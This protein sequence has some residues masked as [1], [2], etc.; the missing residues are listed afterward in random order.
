M[1][2]ARGFPGKYL[3]QLEFLKANGSADQGVLDSIESY[4]ALLAGAVGR[5]WNVDEEAL[6]KRPYKLALMYVDAPGG[7]APGASGHAGGQDLVLRYIEDIL[8]SSSRASMLALPA[9]AASFAEAFKAAREA[10]ADYF[11]LI[12]FRETERDV[13]LDVDLRV[14]RTGS[15]ATSFRAYRTGNDR[16]KNS[17]A[18]TA[19]L[20]VAALPPLGSLVKRN[21]ESVLV[22]LGKA[23]GLAAG[24]KLVVVKEGSVQVKPE[25]LGIGY[26][27]SAVLAEVTVTAVGEE[28]SSGTIKSAGFFDTVNIGDE[29]LLAPPTA[30]PASAATAEASAQEAWPGLFAAVK[31]LR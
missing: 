13:E 19:E 27:Q 12:S 9:K 28:A 18:R 17:A 23:D 16:L 25:G 24:A 2:K 3:A 8:A 20:L 6:A 30:A 4:D 22:D 26:P 10:E 1:L 14:A 21:Q 29:V 5:N 11:A 7:S 31:A 15:E